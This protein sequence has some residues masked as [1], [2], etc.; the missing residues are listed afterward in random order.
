MAETSVQI[1][2]LWAEESHVPE[3]EA[4]GCVAVLLPVLKP[5]GNVGHLGSV[6]V[7]AL[8]L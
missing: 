3:Q 8:F 2:T 4:S 6:V 1:P 5:S 7:I